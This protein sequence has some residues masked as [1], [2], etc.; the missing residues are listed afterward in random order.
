MEKS[1][2]NIGLFFA[3][4]VLLFKKDFILLRRKTDIENDTHI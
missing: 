1:D 4:K 3:E 2:S